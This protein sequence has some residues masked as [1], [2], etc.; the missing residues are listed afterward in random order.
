[1]KSDSLHT[2]HLSPALAKMTALETLNLN[3][4]KITDKGC[5]HLSPALTK[6]TALKELNLGRYFDWGDNQITDKGCEHLS[7]ALAKM[8]ALERLDLSNNQITDK[9]KMQMQEAWKEA[10]KELTDSGLRDLSL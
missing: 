1:M 2:E 7:P 3:D 9:R 4:N 10:G 8:T 6:M 5:E